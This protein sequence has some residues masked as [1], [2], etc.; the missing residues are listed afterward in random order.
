MHYYNFH[1]G[2]YK[3]HTNHLTLI[4]DLAYR[5][6]LDLYYMNEKPI[7]GDQAARLICMKDHGH[8]VLCI[9]LEFFEET[10][11]GFINKRADAEIAAY[12]TRVEVASKAGKASAAARLNKRATENQQQFN[13]RSTDVQLTNNQ[14]PITNNQNKN[15]NTSADAG[16][17]KKEIFSLAKSSG[18]NA[19]L[20]GKAVK[21]IGEFDTFTALE[22]AAS[23]DD[24]KTAFAGAVRK[25]KEQQEAAKTPEEKKPDY[26]PNE[27][28]TLP[29]GR[30]I[31]KANQAWLQRMMA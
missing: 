27:L 17:L 6:L 13:G 30:Q 19:S 24:P 8:E 23:K 16:D 12:Y 11:E 26:D 5:R 9:L 2:D 15:L 20:V 22:W 14:E 4:E 25:R 31:T 3:S 29:D 28:V 18:L 7:I 10:P 1:I 21:D